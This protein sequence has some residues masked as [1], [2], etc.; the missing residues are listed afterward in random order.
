MSKLYQI[1]SDGSCDL[2]LEQANEY[3]VKIVPFYVSFD[4]EHYYKESEE[5][6]V[7]EFYGMMVENPNVYPKTSLPAIDDYIKAF[8]PYAES[9]VPILCMCISSKLSGSFNAATN[10]RNILL[11]DYP[12]AKITVLDSTVITGL[13]GLL[14]MEAVRMREAG[15]SYEETIEKIEQIKGTGRI[16]FTTADINYLKSGGRVGKLMSLANN[17]LKVKPLII[18]REGELFPSGIV[19]ARKKSYDKI[20]EQVSKYFRDTDENPNDY[21]FY[22]G[23]GYDKEEGEM[24]RELIFS[25]LKTYSNIDRLESF[26]IGATIGVHTGPHPLGIVFIKKYETIS[27]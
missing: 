22:V 8:T 3:G 4:Q 5:V 20:I 26:Q 23:Y 10:A 9:G 1:I 11:D 19:R 18:F 13:Q 21:Q 7:R 12:E 15:L 17:T 16:Y 25:D 14:V 27:K 6:G 2:T 24:F